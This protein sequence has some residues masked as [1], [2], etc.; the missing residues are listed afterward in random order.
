[1]T[2][3][4]LFVALLLL[5]SS[6]YASP[7]ENIPCEKE[8]RAEAE[9]LIDEVGVLKYDPD[10][11]TYEMSYEGDTIVGT[12]MFINDN[13]HFFREVTVKSDKNCKIL[14]SEIE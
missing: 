3:E 12:F 13:G 5:S 7:A 9:R 14:S 10:E 4:F 11:T 8:I 1:M 6:V 2:K